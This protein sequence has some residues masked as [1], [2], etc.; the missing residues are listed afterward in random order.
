MSLDDGAADRSCHAHP[1]CLRRER[2]LRRCCR[3]LRSTPM[4]RSVPHDMNLLRIV[5]FCFDDECRVQSLTRTH[6]FDA[7]RGRVK[8]SPAPTE[9]EL[10]R[11]SMSRSATKS[12]RSDTASLGFAP[13]APMVSWI[14]SLICNNLSQRIRSEARSRSSLTLAHHR[15]DPLH[16]VFAYFHSAQARSHPSSTCHF[17]TTAP[18]AGSSHA[19]PASANFPI[20]IRPVMFGQF[21]NFCQRLLGRF[22][23]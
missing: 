23:R 6:G 21:I 4:Q 9:H 19:Q 1:L 16:H 22:T 8:S 11:S 17:V 7:V 2:R 12:V 15:S 3:A 18:R 14:A 13:C 20:V 10:P 5:P